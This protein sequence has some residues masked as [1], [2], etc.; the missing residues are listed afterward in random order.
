[1]PYI[2]KRGDSFRIV[3]HLDGKRYRHALKTSEESVANSV[4]G[5]GAQENQHTVILWLHE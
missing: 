2:E 4:I 1:M 3:F 5:G